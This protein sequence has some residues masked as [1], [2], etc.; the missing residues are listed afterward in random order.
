M[1]ARDTG[2]EKGVMGWRCGRW[3]RWWSWR[4]GR[5]GIGGGWWVVGHR[6]LK[7][8]WKWTMIRG[9]SQGG[10]GYRG[11]SR[12]DWWGRFLW[13]D[14]RSMS[15]MVWSRLSNVQG[16]AVIRFGNFRIAMQASNHLHKSFHPEIS[17]NSPSWYPNPAFKT[18]PSHSLP[19]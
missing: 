1:M 10:F 16:H 11:M 8:N 4:R 2:I 13:R 5:W 6:E 3:W 14:G 17:S 12:L 19:L 15:C 9:E 7:R 18:M